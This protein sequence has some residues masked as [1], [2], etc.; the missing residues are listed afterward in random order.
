M[1]M[2]PRGTVVIYGKRFEQQD[3]TK[4]RLWS[5]RFRQGRAVDGRYIDRA[6]DFR[7]L[8]HGH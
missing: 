3:F 7:A 5:L 4:S 8:A 6:D 1:E 2:E